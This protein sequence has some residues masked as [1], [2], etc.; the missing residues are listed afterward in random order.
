[1]RAGQRNDIADFRRRHAASSPASVTRG[2]KAI[3]PRL[4]NL[5]GSFIGGTSAYAL[6]RLEFCLEFTDGPAPPVLD[7]LPDASE[8]TLR[9]HWD[10]I[11]NQLHG[12]IDYVKRIESNQS[13]SQRTAATFRS[14]VRTVRELDQFAR[15]LRWVITV[16]EQDT[17][18]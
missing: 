2:A 18:D 4:V 5:L 12:I 8:R 1:L 16:T 17:T 6:A 3:N 10:G 13:S 15:A 9:E 7:R 11:E 14:L